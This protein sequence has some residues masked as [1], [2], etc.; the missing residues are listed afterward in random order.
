MQDILSNLQRLLNRIFFYILCLFASS[1]FFLSNIGISYAADGVYFSAPYSGE[2]V[3]SYEVTL[4]VARKNQQQFTIPADC[5]AAEDALNGGATQWGN[6]VQRSIWNKV[7][8]D[9]DYYLFLQNFPRPPLYDFVSHYDFMNTVLKEDPVRTVYAEVIGGNTD[10]KARSTEKTEKDNPHS[11]LV[12]DVS[13][14]AA[15]NVE[16]VFQ[17]TGGIFHG[18]LF[19]DQRG[20]HCEQ[21]P[22]TPGFRLIAV[23]FADINDDNFLDAILRL[24]PLGR[25]TRST[26]IVLP[27][28]RKSATDKPIIL[29][30]G[31]NH[32]PLP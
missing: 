23:D 19:Y 10:Q 28:T 25:G 15:S 7:Q 31:T 18:N 22:D 26:P 14:L 12:R 17:I 27:V 24:I 11:L 3:T 32:L 20:L 8:H 29:K 13:N 1:S 5:R 16:H 21:A 30:I 9:C 2:K 6:R 4:P